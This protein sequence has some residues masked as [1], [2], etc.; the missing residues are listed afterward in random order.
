M[1]STIADITALTINFKTP[2]LVY[3]CLNSFRNFYPDVYHLVIDNG[4]CQQSDRTLSQLHDKKLIKLIK[5]T[6]NV[7]HGLALNQGIELV[8]TSYVF[9]LDSDTRTERGGFLEKM[10]KLFETDD[11][12]FA[13]GW[14]RKVGKTGVAYRIQSKAPKDALPYVHPYACLLDVAKFRQLRPFNESG[15]PALKTM[16]DARELGF[17]L[18]D[19][20]IDEYIWHKVAGTRGLFGG[21]F[22]VGTREIPGQWSRRPI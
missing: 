9:L 20:P 4:G 15:A 3:D 18:A 13:V 5:N 2:E 22:K 19:F 16:Y 8:G 6:E 17:H 21:R 12:L 14:L 10:L 1:T 7:G 11:Q